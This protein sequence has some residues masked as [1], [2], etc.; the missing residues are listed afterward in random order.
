MINIDEVLNSSKYGRY[1][2]DPTTMALG[3]IHGGRKPF[4]VNVAK[5][6]TVSK[7]VNDAVVS[8]RA[9]W[10]KNGNQDQ[11]VYTHKSTHPDNDPDVLKADPFNY[12]YSRLM[13]GVSKFRKSHS[14]LSVKYRQ[15][16]RALYKS[17]QLICPKLDLV[18]L[19]QAIEANADQVLEWGVNPTQAVLDDMVS[20]EE[21]ILVHENMD[22]EGDSD[23]YDTEP[24]MRQ[25]SNGRSFTP[26]SHR[27]ERDLQ[28]CYILLRDLVHSATPVE[29]DQLL[30][31]LQQKLCD[32]L[33]EHSVAQKSR[34]DYRRFPDYGRLKKYGDR[35]IPAKP[36]L[37]P[38]QEEKDEAGFDEEAWL[39]KNIREWQVWV[40]DLDVM[41]EIQHIIGEGTDRTVDTPQY[42]FTR[43]LVEE[44]RPWDDGPR[45]QC[46]WPSA[47]E[48]QSNCKCSWYQRF[49]NETQE[50]RE[51][52]N[53]HLLV[54]RYN[55]PP[56]TSG[57]VLKEIKSFSLKA[58]QVI[59]QANNKREQEGKS[60]LTAEWLMR[61]AGFASWYV[62]EYKASMKRIWAM[63][64]AKPW[65]N[66]TAG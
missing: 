28:E 35:E 17:F 38:T 32:L 55:E 5:D 56:K 9:C 23:D 12:A 40:C 25:L 62:A 48:N 29:R 63:A 6:G 36:S 11:V 3:F 18:T 44:I 61:E 53:D 13:D 30:D 45:P 16:L 60:P 50:L 42:L 2:S 41:D 47:S 51:R 24:L 33:F 39:A 59:L 37:W 4:T 8:G 64:K 65:I 46:Y 57:G 19:K 49:M 43:K 20:I 34:K 26:S 7:K 22:H 27:E 52:F 14:K 21:T 10:V 66:M 1:N 15:L 54:M 58:E 31:E